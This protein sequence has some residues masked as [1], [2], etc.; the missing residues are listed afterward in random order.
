MEA[1]AI[2]FVT[3]GCIVLGFVGFIYLT[4]WMT[5][6]PMFKPGAGKDEL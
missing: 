5:N 2:V 3:L 4:S 1:K 6:I